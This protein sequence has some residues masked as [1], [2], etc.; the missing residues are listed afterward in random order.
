M[1]VAVGGSDPF[2]SVALSSTV[3]HYTPST[4]RWML[5]NSLPYNVV[6]PSLVRSS[7]NLV[8]LIGGLVVRIS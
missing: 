5:G 7:H 8:Y 3:Q 4:D 1:L 2:N 6:R